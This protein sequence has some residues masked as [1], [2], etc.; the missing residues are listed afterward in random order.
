MFA[1]MPHDA[2]LVA[3][4]YTEAL[5]AAQGDP[6]QAAQDLVRTARSRNDG[7]LGVQTFWLVDEAVEAIGTALREVAR[8]GAAAAAA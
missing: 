5:Q 4:L 2:P 1:F 3:C 7:E 8:R 6:L